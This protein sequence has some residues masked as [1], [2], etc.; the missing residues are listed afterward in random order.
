MSFLRLI[1]SRARI[2]LG[3]FLGLLPSGVLA[4][5]IL[6]IAPAIAQSPNPNPV[7]ASSGEGLCGLP[8]LARLRNHSV[9]AGETLA[10]IA[11]QYG[12]TPATLKGFNP[13]VR[14]GTV[15]PGNTLQ[16]PPYN[17]IRVATGG[18]SWKDLATRYQVRSDVLFEVNGC[19]NSPATAFIPGIN[20]VPG[21]ETSS[22]TLTKAP[23]DQGVLL[24]FPLMQ[25]NR[26]LL[27]Y[28]W[29]MDPQ[30][31]QVVFHG[32]VDLAASLGDSVF[33]IGQGT[34]AYAGKQEGYGLLVVVNHA[35]GLQTRYAQLREINVRAGEDVSRNTVL[36]LVGQTGIPSS[37]APHLHFEV[38]LNSDVGWVA[39]D[40]TGYFDEKVVLGN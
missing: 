40:P 26:I 22:I 16:I 36:G 11:N 32:G 18:Q 21:I 9:T 12:L 35:N 20:W 25:G 30:L 6:G 29:Q 10:S 15:Q 8:A 23:S 3:V 34:V 5:G 28:G 37:K 24:G 33:A 14:S 38:R 4:S 17:G 1:P 19:V 27:G 13:A 7:A 31:N 2:G 39:Q